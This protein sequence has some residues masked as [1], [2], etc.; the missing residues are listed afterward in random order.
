MP[1]PTSTTITLSEVKTYGQYPVMNALTVGN[2]RIT[3]TIDINGSTVLRSGSDS[4]TNTRTQIRLGYGGTSDYAHR[5]NTRHDSGTNSNNAVD[6]YLWQTGDAT[7]ALGTKLGM[8]ITNQGVGLGT[9]NPSYPLHLTGAGVNSLLL[10]HT[11]ANSEASVKH[12]VD[13]TYDWYIGTN[14]GSIG[15]GSLGFYVGNYGTVMTFNSAGNAGIGFTNP[16]I[17]LRVANVGI[18]YGSFI[19]VSPES[20]SSW[21]SGTT[22]LI[23]TTWNWHGLGNDVTSIYTPGSQSNAVRLAFNSGGTIYSNA[24]IGVNMTSGINGSYQLDVN[25]D[26]ICSDWFRT[27]GSQGWWNETHQGGWYMS[28]STWMRMNNSRYI[29]AG[30]GTISTESRIGQ[31]TSAPDFPV[32]IRDNVGSTQSYRYLNSGGI[33]YAGSYYMY[34]GLWGAGR[35]F[36]TEL[37]ATSDSRIK[38]NIEDIHD[39]DALNIIRQ[40]EPKKY[41]YIDTVLRGTKSVWGFLAQQVES[42]LPYSVGKSKQYIPDIYDL[43]DVTKNTTGDYLLTLNTKNTIGLTTTDP[44]TQISLRLYVDEQNTMKYATVKEIID[45]NSF[46]INEDISPHQHPDP[47]NTQNTQG[48]QEITKVFVYG[49]QVDDFRTLNKQAIFT[50]ATAALQEVDRQLQQTKQDLIAA[51]NT[52]QQQNIEITQLQSELNTILQQISV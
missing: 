11:S 48:N 12:Y 44:S 34:Y 6:F 16:N 39:G 47:S 32:D 23:G 52:A 17:R 45:N 46:T 21:P 30:S 8:S 38:E 50:M 31:G 10:S 37:N 20:A 35:I 13:G 4:G 19:T 42:V 49:K 5:I 18:D 3:G 9:T 40:L 25:G 24:R 15:S 1:Y 14:V 28:D 43:A 22:S 2:S 41:S 33:G 27:R 7:S 29:F 51:E 26:C 36:C